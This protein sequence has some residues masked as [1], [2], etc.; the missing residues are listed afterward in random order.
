MPRRK[1]VTEIPFDVAL[2]GDRVVSMPTQYRTDEARRAF[3]KTPPDPEFV[4]GLKAAQELR[5]MMLAAE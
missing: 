2:W 5:R 1:Y 4:E 3:L